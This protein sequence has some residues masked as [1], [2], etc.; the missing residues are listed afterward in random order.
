MNLPLG[1]NFRHQQDT[2]TMHVQQN[3]FGVIFLPKPSHVERVLAIYVT[4]F[5][6]W[7]LPM[8]LRAPIGLQKTLFS[9]A[10]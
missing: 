10:Q 6:T 5:V 3:M 4:S 2:E 1:Y 7:V 8:N 9:L